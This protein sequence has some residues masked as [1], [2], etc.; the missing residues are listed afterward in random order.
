MGIVGDFNTFVQEQ[1]KKITSEPIINYTSPFSKE[2]SNLYISLLDGSIINT[3]RLFFESDLLDLYE[4]EYFLIKDH[5]FS[6]DLFNVKS[7]AE[8][9][10][11]ISIIQKYK[12][13]EDSSAGSPVGEE[14]Y[15]GDAIENEE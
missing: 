3:I 13:K 7:P 1:N 9:Y 15:T 4:T 8:I 10:A 12:E 2:V 5:N 14:L 11:Y 6:Q